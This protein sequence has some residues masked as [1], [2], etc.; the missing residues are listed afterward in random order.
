MNAPDRNKEV[1]KITF[2][3]FYFIFFGDL[4]FLSAKNQV[5]I[6][7]YIIYLA[8][9]LAASWTLLP[10]APASLTSDSVYIQW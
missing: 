3:G 7:F 10:G 5:F 1:K 9:N 6:F 4:N 8:F 2:I